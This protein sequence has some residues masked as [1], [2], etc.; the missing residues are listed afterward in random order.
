MN[1][2]AASTE[3]VARERFEQVVRRLE[4]HGCG[5]SMNLFP[6]I[7]RIELKDR[8]GKVFETIEVTA[9]GVIVD[10]LEMSLMA[11]LGY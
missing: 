9:R 8:N 4:A 3:P 1:Q 6:K 7:N 10:G 5:Y 2:T 11:Y